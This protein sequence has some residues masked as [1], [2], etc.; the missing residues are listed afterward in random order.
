MK[1]F[2]KM[3][4]P[5]D[6][7]SIKKITMVLALFVLGGCEIDMYHET[8]LSE[9]KIQV[10]KSVYNEQRLASEV[11][12]PFLDGVARAYDKRGVGPMELT[13]SYDPASRSNTAMKATATAKSLAAVLNRYG[14]RNQNVSVMPVQK[15]GSESIVFISFDSYGALPP[16]DCSM[17]AGME[18]RMVDSDPDYKLGC[19]INTV[20]TKQLARPKDIAGQGSQDHFTDGRRS[21]RIVEIYRQGSKDDPLQGESSSGL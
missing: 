3:V 11:D 4:S 2:L 5:M 10:E 9:N 17:I 14:V 1:H 13:V 12:E 18:T 15:Q 19:S 7:S 6:T 20:M 8:Y 16:K 21:T